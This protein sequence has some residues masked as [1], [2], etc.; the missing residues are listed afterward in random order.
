MLPRQRDSYGR[1]PRSGRRQGRSERP[2]QGRRGRG[3]A[4]TLEG[5][6]GASGFDARRQEELGDAL[7]EA[8]YEDVDPTSERLRAALGDDYLGSDDDVD[9]GGGDVLAIEEL[10]DGDFTHPVAQEL[11]RTMTTVGLPAQPDPTFVPRVS[12]ALV[13]DDLRRVLS[14]AAMEP[15]SSTEGATARVVAAT[16]TRLRLLTVGRRVEDLRSKLQ[17]TDPAEQPDEYRAVFTDLLAREAE[18]RQLRNRTLGGE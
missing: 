11:W 18:F 8:I 12:D 6:V 16:M 10:D 9:G 3:G 5:A 14:V 17:R 4:T 7:Y 1:E 13:S 15:L 2:G